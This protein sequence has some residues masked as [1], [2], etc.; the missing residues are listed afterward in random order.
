MDDDDRLE[1]EMLHGK[2]IVAEF[3]DFHKMLQD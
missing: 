1:K 3:D 2:S